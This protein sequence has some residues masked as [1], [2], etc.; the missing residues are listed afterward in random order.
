MARAQGTPAV[1]AGGVVLSSVPQLQH[2][3]GSLDV[4]SAAPDESVVATAA[5]EAIR[6]RAGADFGVGIAAFPVELDRPDSFVHIAI[7]TPERTR[8][9]RFG[10]ATHPAIRQPITAKRALNAMRLLLLNREPERA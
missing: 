2:L 9:L 6:L 10:T 1:F 4:G 8:R 5:A 3:L 7:A